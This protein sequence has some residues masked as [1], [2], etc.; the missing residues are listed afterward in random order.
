MNELDDHQPRVASWLGY[1]GLVPFVALSSLSAFEVANAA[2]WRGALIGYGAV[3][4][5]FVG[6]QHWAFAMMQP[7]M[8]AKQRNACFVWSVVP[9]LVAWI[10]VALPTFV[11]L[12]QPRL[13][14]LT[15]SVL[16]IGG[17][18]IHYIQDKRLA[19]VVRFPLW[20]LPLRFRLTIVACIC[21]ALGASG[22]T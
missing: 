6:A 4:L 20:Y 15:Q 9:A 19:A 18:L 3:I 7:T 10:A 5:S 22:F 17:F 16:I 14:T 12:S 13:L 2:L 11:M 21:L 1:G 8:S